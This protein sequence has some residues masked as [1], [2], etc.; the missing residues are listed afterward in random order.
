MRVM[1]KEITDAAVPRFEAIEQRL[2]ALQERVNELE[3]KGYVGIWKSGKEY[4]PHSEVTH[5]GARWLSHKRTSAK[6][7]DDADWLM[8]EKSFPT[9]SPR[10]DETVARGR[11]GS[12]GPPAHPRRP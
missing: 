8:V 5:D 10:S 12:G 3:R 1:L 2:D 4:S 7:G 11:N 6:P 9:A